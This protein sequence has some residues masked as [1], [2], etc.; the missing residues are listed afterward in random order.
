M[1]VQFAGANLSSLE[2]RLR[3]KSQLAVDYAEKVFNEELPK[4]AEQ[5]RTLLDHATTAY[6]E[7]RISRGQGNTAGRNDQEDLI[8][9]IDSE[10]KQTARGVEGRYGFIDNPPD[11]ADI[12]DWGLGNVPPAFSLLDSY[13][14]ARDRI[15]GRLK[16]LVK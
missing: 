1:G 11:H 10:V 5:Q 16:D 8:G 12:Q 3:L 6:G 13:I 15:I 7:Y 4:A 14:V 2:T 9:S